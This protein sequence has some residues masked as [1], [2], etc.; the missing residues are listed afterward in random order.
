MR[1]VGALLIFVGVIL[2]AL[3]VTIGW[4]LAAVGAPLA[5]VSGWHLTKPEGSPRAA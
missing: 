2:F 4:G 3:A 5:L 1:T